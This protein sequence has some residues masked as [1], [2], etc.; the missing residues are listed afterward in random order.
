MSME[1]K[2]NSQTFQ[3]FSQSTFK[4]NSLIDIATIV[5]ECNKKSI[6][7]KLCSKHYYYFHRYGN[8]DPIKCQCCGR[9]SVFF[10]SKTWHYKKIN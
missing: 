7:K 8:F 3:D 6:A 9:R 2:Q 4:P 1:E 5:K 10:R